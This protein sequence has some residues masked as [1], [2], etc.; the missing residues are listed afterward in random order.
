[1]MPVTGQINRRNEVL[2]AST[3]REFNGGWNV[4]DSELS[5][6]T[7]YAVRLR[8]MYRAPDG[9]L[10]VRHGTKLFADLS[11]ALEADI[12]SMEYFNGFIVAVGTNGAIVAVDGTGA[13]YRL[14][15]DDIA[16]TRPGS[17]N[18]W[19]LTSFVTF[20]QFKRDL[21]ICNGK[22]KPLLC[23]DA[24]RVEYLQDLA[25]LT[26]ANT[27]VGRY[28]ITHG[29]F[30]VIAGDPL[31]PSIINISAK[32]ASGTWVGDPGSDAT[33]VDLAAYISSGTPVITGLGSFRDKLVVQFD[34]NLVLMTLGGYESAVHIPVVD[35]V[36]PEH[37]S[38]GQRT[39]QALGDDM[40]FTD[41]VGIPSI[42]RALFTGTIQPNRPSQLVDPEIQKDLSRLTLGS[43]EDR[44][45]SVYSNLDGQYMLFVPNTN[46]KVDT[47]ET[48]GFIYTLI[49]S[50]KVKAWSDFTE[51]NWTSACRS[52]EGRVFF[53]KG[54]EIYLLGNDNNPL[55]RDRIGAEET[56]DDGTMWDDATGWSPV[57]DMADSGV[58]IIFDWELPWSDFDRRGK[59]KVTKYLS[60][61]VEGDGRFTAEM[62]VDNLYEDRSDPGELW[63][64]GST[65]DDNLGFNRYRDEPVRTPELSMDF[66]GGDAIGFGG[67]FGPRFGGGRSTQEE[68][69]YA[70]P[71]KGKIFKLRFHGETDEP[72][73]FVSVTLMYHDGSIRR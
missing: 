39:H 57:A 63:T 70:W 69:L 21:I 72:L 26:N 13:S 51:F 48:R 54:Q 34:K 65:W 31:A 8:N 68:M 23:S 15:D 61:D 5:L 62:Y 27:P 14:W 11:E 46:Y 32:N 1:M 28:C 56:W 24:M 58:P 50:L 20:T 71:C 3:I 67:S 33:Q 30:V 16:G 37:G 40:L 53:S 36:I 60:M 22:D 47:V 59:V 49:E 6:T 41:V 29:Q 17:P 42:K 2:K 44:V 55:S 18:G 7:E 52:Q 25:T 73:R 43:L 64:D 19:G 38:I 12:V 45:F 4:I 9:S 10:R 35:D 66:V